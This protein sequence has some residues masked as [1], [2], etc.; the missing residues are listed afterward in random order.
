MVKVRTARFAVLLDAQ[1]IRVIL[2]IFHGRVVASFARAARQGDDD[3]VVLLSHC[4]NSL[5]APPVRL[6]R[7][8]RWDASARLTAA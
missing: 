6:S 8:S 1:S 7:E 4:S 5:K 3:S 2:L